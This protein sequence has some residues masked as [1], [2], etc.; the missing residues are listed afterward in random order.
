M[1]E[2]HNLK[3]FVNRETEI[4]SF[5]FL[6]ADAE[7]RIFLLHGEEGVGKSC[8]IH[9]ARRDHARR[10]MQ[11]VFVDFRQSRRLGAEPDAVIH[12]LGDRLG[13]PLS[14]ALEP[15]LDAPPPALP[16]AEALAQWEQTLTRS[17]AQAVAAARSAAGSGLSIGGN[18][19]IEGGDLVVGDKFVFQLP[20]LLTHWGD[21]RRAGQ[22]RRAQ[23]RSQS[24]QRALR[25]LSDQQPVILYFD[26]CDEAEPPVRA[27]LEKE[28]VGLLFDPVETTANLWIV[29]IGRQMPLQAEAQALAP[30]LRA[31]EVKPLSPA[32]VA[33]YWEE[34]R[35]LSPQ[36]TAQ[37]I[38]FSR[39]NPFL[40]K[41]MADNLDGASRQEA[42]RG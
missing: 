21:S 16:D 5:V 4:D 24:F 32:V 30:I 41:R 14:S 28:L 35:G 8:L 12:F 6:L 3:H 36:K 34:K 31:Q 37:A 2:Y 25:M 38:E 13:P 42:G 33:R 15:F 39:G 10:E 27:W 1:A 11:A 19:E 40:L 7:Q 17:L 18:V 26:H 23:A 9:L 22:E 29:L 20:P